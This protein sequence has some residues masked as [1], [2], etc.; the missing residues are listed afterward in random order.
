MNKQ[1]ALATYR[2]KSMKTVLKRYQ[3]ADQEII[4][5]EGDPDMRGIAIPLPKPPDWDLIANFGMLPHKQTWE[6]ARPKFPSKLRL[7]SKMKNKEGNF[8]S[9]NEIW[10]FLESNIDDYR[11][12]IKWMEEQWYYRLYGYWFF[13]NGKPTYVT[14]K[15]F[16][17]LTYWYID[18]GYPDYRS[19][20]RK[21]WLFR[22]FTE[23]DTYDF[24]DKDEQGNAIAV[25]GYYH[26]VDIGRRVSYGIIYPKFRREG[27]T[28]RAQ[29]DL[30]ESLSKV[31]QA[32]GGTQSKNEEDA[33]KAFTDKM[34]KP[35]KKIPFFFRPET[36]KLDPK[37]IMEFDIPVTGKSS[38][39]TLGLESQISYE[40]SDE[41]AYDGDKLLFFHDDEIGKA[42]K[43]NIIKRHQITK[44]CLAQNSGFNIHGFT[45]KTSTA[46]EMVAGGGYNF[47]QLIKQSDFYHRN[48]NGQ[49]VSGL[50]VL[51]ISS[52][53]GLFVDEYGNSVIENPKEP[54]YI[55]NEGK[56]YKTSIGSR[57][58]IHNERNS[59]LAN[60][61][62]EGWH[63]VVRQIPIKLAE[64]FLGSSNSLGFNIQVLTT[65]ISELINKTNIYRVGDL[66]RVNP[67][68]KFSRI[69]FV[70]NPN[71]RFR[72]SEVLRDNEAN[73]FYRG[74]D[75]LWYPSGGKYNAGAD[76]YK[77]GE[78][79]GSQMS[80]GGL[81][82]K[83][84]YDPLID[85]QDKSVDQWETDRFVLTYRHRPEQKKD[86][87]DDVLKA[88]LYFGCPVLAETNVPQVIDDFTEWGAYPFLKFLRDRDGRFK[89]TP[90]FH[91]GTDSKQ[92]LFNGL[93]DYISRRGL[94]ENH[95]DL[96]QEAFDIPDIRRMTEYDL[97]TAAGLAEY[98]ERSDY[99]EFKEI[100][101]TV[102]I[103]L[104]DWFEMNL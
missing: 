102:G 51:F 54:I 91:S 12:E 103:N 74:G 22:D 98:A 55:I 46:G 26:R 88:C 59:F 27:A 14:G 42:E 70:D 58:F 52:E 84:K 2:S 16:Y 39:I 89:K 53:D 93:R 94:Y 38:F 77:F 30:F 96:L 37:K 48:K 61:D 40:S 41:G 99:G 43:F 86:F 4:V 75:G 73:K 76:A 104:E 47:Q 69:K 21:Y 97:L 28:F 29:C 31:S 32:N 18:I 78:V 1:E 65:R 6:A 57:E 82:V 66:V 60:N 34:V 13:L 24:R 3:D 101:S 45:V 85:P 17:Y 81:A 19:R 5:N 15:H 92:D 63:E 49:T 36:V 68:D 11:D 9:I 100:E 90:G 33:K 87:T 79:A 71:G 83:K 67:K 80:D 62:L 64:C 56:K 10:D 20:D 7:I 72:L 44:R 23:K 35:S 50:Y 25:D 95:L 8:F